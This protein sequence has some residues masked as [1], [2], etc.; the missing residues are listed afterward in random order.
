MM[1]RRGYAPAFA[2]VALLSAMCATAMWWIPV[3]HG[4]WPLASPDTFIYFI[5]NLEYLRDSLARGWGMWWTPLQNCG[6]P[7]FGNG[8]IGVLYPPNWLFLVLPPPWALAVDN[9]LHL[10][11]GPFGVLL[12][13]RLLRLHP[14]AALT[15]AL[16]LLAGSNTWQLAIWQPTVFAPYMLIPW[17]LA[18][19]EYTVRRPSFV[20]MTG[21]ATALTLQLLTGYPQTSLF[22]YQ[23]VGLRIL[24]QL[25]LRGGGASGRVG[26]RRG[27]SGRLGGGEAASGNGIQR[28]LHPRRRLEPQRFARRRIPS[29][30]GTVP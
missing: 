29:D 5:P 8:Q 23:V 20:A 27:G 6:Q 16:A 19:V 14:A 2:V 26:R 4:G 22:T 21:L 9:T 18:A 10:M 1:L 17:V 7:F 11:M 15:G 24:W 25:P 12:W 3:A 13:A 28:R 30:V